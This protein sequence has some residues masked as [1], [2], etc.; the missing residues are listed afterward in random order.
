MPFAL[1]DV[2]ACSSM[3]LK[4]ASFCCS[5]WILYSMMLLRL[6]NSSVRSPRAS[7]RIAVKV[8]SILSLGIYA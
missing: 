3:A 2:A 7:F 8:S 5:F 4:V 1:F 6:R